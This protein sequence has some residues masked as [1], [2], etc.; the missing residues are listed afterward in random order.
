ML[1]RSVELLEEELGEAKAS[2]E[3]AK[4]NEAKWKMAK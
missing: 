4:A 3:E 1:K 2:T